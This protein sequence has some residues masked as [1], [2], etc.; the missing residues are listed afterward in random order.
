ML[1]VRKW[2]ENWPISFFFKSES[3]YE[4]VQA[5]RFGLALAQLRGSDVGVGAVRESAT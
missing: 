3:S 4:C 1:S 2:R 5:Y